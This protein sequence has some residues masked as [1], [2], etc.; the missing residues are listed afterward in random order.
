MILTKN[1]KRTIEH[2]IGADVQL[3]GIKSVE[4]AVLKGMK[5][6]GYKN[7]ET[8]GILLESDKTVYDSFVEDVVIPKTWFFRNKDSFLFLKNKYIKEWRESNKAILKVLSIPCSTGEEPYSIAAT[9]FEGGLS[10]EQF[11]IDAMDI[12]NKAI[13]FAECGIYLKTHTHMEDV[14]YSGKF[15]YKKDNR[16]L[17]DDI[18]KSQI[19]FSHVNLLNME[20]I[21]K[22]KYDLIFC[23]NVFI[24]FNDAARKKVIRNLENK[25]AKDGIIFTGH[26]E[27][28]IFL[29][30]GLKKINFK[31][32]FACREEIIDGEELKPY[33]RK[34]IINKKRIIIDRKTTTVN[35]N[36]TNNT[37]IKSKLKKDEISDV[38]KSESD[39]REISVFEEIEFYAN[40][41]DYVKAMELCN[42][43]IDG[44]SEP[45]AEIFCLR[46]LVNQLQGHFDAAENDFNKAIYLNPESYETLL[47]MSNLM[48]RKGLMKKAQLFKNRA[49]RL[50]NK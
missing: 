13:K 26:A 18:L 1:I 49:K 40:K 23:R 21:S 36:N 32:I 31:N 37:K 7:P 46:G 17:V 38:K 34:K 8:Y 10:K 45:D 41:E 11:H 4:S 12:S 9:L 28:N 47:H 15:L 19:T 30:A 33:K 42:S 2:K 16:I 14:N 22:R 44:N 5:S 25:L 43:Y 20:N 50:L 29:N 6:Y 3:L 35:T 39:K 24:Y 27:L 48:E